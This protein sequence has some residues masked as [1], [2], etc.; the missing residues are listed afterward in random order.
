MPV[1][2]HEA[3]KRPKLD[4]GRGRHGSTSSSATPTGTNSSRSGSGSGSGSGSEM[5]KGSEP[6]LS[7]QDSDE[8]TISMAD[9]STS[10]LQL[11][12]RRLADHAGRSTG[13]TQSEVNSPRESMHRHARHSSW[14]ENEATGESRHPKLP[15][16]SDMLEEGGIGN[17]ASSTSESNA[18]ASGMAAG[19]SHPWQGPSARQS[20]RAPL[21]RHGPSSC[22]SSGSG[23]SV[24][25]YTRTPGEGPLPIH[26]LLS[27]RPI[28][29]EPALF[30][31]KPPAAALASLADHGH[32]PFAQVHG[33]SGYGMFS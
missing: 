22:G 20:G 24:T 28:A 21:L 9:S 26:A 3:A 5:L 10:S 30:D 2:A 4:S 13:D 25:S 14:R 19:A 11:P 23:N 27:D 12:A 32:R 6:A 16:L 1:L 33:T 18:Y 31:R 7:R 29:P 8:S 15:S 17:S